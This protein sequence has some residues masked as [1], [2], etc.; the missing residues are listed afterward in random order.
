MG[1]RPPPVEHLARRLVDVGG[2]RPRLRGPDADL[3]H[4]GDDLAGS[5]HDCDLVAGLSRDHVWSG[6][7]PLP[8]CAPHP[9]NPSPPPPLPPPPP[10]SPPFAPTPLL[11]RH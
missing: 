1:A 3:V 7:S 5:P 6:L 10:R 2:R 4:L 9:P 8:T 11:P